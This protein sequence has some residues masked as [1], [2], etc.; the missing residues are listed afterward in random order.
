MA[1]TLEQILQNLSAPQSAPQA[2][3]PNSLSGILNI[4]QKD[5]QDANTFANIQTQTDA[6]GIGASAPLKESIRYVQG[7]PLN[8]E[9]MADAFALKYG[10]DA[11]KGVI[12]ALP[13]FNPAQIQNL[14]R[15][16]EQATSEYDAM[17]KRERRR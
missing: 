15:H 6:R 9:G 10:A 4:H 7:L 1:G 8:Y 17:Y 12:Q 5:R 11:L 16:I 14:A 2:Y 13:S 3:A